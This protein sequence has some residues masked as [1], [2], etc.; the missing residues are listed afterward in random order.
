M[1]VLLCTFS[2]AECPC[3]KAKTGPESFDPK[4]HWRVRDFDPAGWDGKKGMW[5]RFQRIKQ[6]QRVERPAAQGDGDWSFVGDMEEAEQPMPIYSPD[7]RSP[8][9]DT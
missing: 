4:A 6:D 3:P 1:V 7:T 8:V 2:R 9:M 5:V